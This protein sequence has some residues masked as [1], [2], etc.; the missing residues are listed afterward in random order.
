MQS[1][2]SLKKTIADMVAYSQEQNE[3]V[4]KL[5]LDI[6]TLEFE[7]NEAKL[8]LSQCSTDVYSNIADAFRIAAVE[9]DNG[10]LKRKVEY[11]ESK[12]W[13]KEYL[14]VVAKLE[15]IVNKTKAF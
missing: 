7:L 10:R 13:R 14:K 1:R 11:L 5:N 15:K 2:R 12:N 3:S 8:R 6:L 4:I 9:T